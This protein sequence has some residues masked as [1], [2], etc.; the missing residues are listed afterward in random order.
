MVPWLLTKVINF[1][2]S[3]SLG[4]HDIKFFLCFDTLHQ[5]F[6]LKLQF[7]PVKLATL[8]LCL[9]LAS[10]TATPLESAGPP[11]STGYFQQEIEFNNHNLDAWRTEQEL[12]N[13][14][15]A[16]CLHTH[17]NQKHFKFHTNELHSKS[18]QVDCFE[19]RKYISRNSA[20]N[21]GYFQS[22]LPNESG[23]G[24]YNVSSSQ[25][26]RAPNLILDSKKFCV[27]N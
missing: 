13:H 5:L 4:T 9:Q 16:H 7:F 18:W 14:Q 27:L 3:V 2:F 10:L 19:S 24:L 25:C 17:A 11:R 15:A 1:L 8:S 23:R 20:T 21:D 6:F 26:L 12:F 22:Q